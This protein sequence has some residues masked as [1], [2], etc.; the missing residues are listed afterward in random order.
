MLRLRRRLRHALR[1]TLIGSAAVGV[2]LLLGSAGHASRV[3]AES[4]ANTPAALLEKAHEAGAAARLPV[5]TL[6]DVNGSITPGGSPLTVTIANANDNAYITFSGTANQRVALSITSVSISFSYVSIRKPDGSDLVSPTAVFAS[7]KFIDTVTLPTTGTYTIFI[8]PVGSATGSMTLTL[9]D[10]PADAS[11]TISPSGPSVTATITVPGQ[12]AVETWSGTQGDRVS[13]NATNIMLNSGYEIVKI[14]KPT[15]RRSRARGAT[16]SHYFFDTMTLPTTG[17]YKVLVDPQDAATGST[18]LTMYSVPADAAGKL[19]IPGYA[20]TATVT[21]PGHNPTYTFRGGALEPVKVTITGSTILYS[22]ISIKKPDGS[23]LITSSVFTG[24]A[25]VGPTI[26]PVDGVYSLVVDPVQEN[27]GSMTVKVVRSTAWQR[28]PITRV[29]CKSRGRHARALFRCLADPVNSLT[30]AFT[31][32]ETDLTLSGKGLPFA[33]TRSYNSD[34]S[35]SGRLGQ[36]WT[37]SY[38][39]SLAIQQNGD[40]FLHGEDG[41]EVRYSLQEDGTFIAENG[42][43][44]TLSSVTGGYQLVT[45]DQVTYRFDSNG[46]LTSM[47]DRNGNAVSLAYDGSGRLATITDSV[48]RTITFT[49]NADGTLARVSVPDGRSVVYGYTAGRLTSVTDPANH[50]TTY[51]YDANGRLDQITDPNGHTAQTTYG[52]DGRVTQQTDALGHTTTFTWDPSTQTETATDARGNTWKDVYSS[53][54]LLKEIDALGNV[55]HDRR[56]R[57]VDDLHLRLERQPGLGH[58]SAREQ[59]DV[60]V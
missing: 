9:Y 48:G 4:Q 28:L 30:G 37:D 53:N 36:G 51:H 31:D 14:L 2:A 54:V 60:R 42:G 49:S 26:L 46:K 23:N 24:S 29:A 8:D 27:T 32:S 58:R 7:G 22:N 11:G 12:N 25:T 19:A 6:S 3:H 39:A 20:R 16:S 44:S 10:V 57:D 18:A 45:Q 38:S 34:D 59:D 21:I 35:T 55:T 40:V 41:Q 15:G 1:G 52:S 50:A 5:R 43:Q 47:T 33:F 13:L 56:P 17:T